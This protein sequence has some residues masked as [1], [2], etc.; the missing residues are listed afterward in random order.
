MHL[1]KFSRLKTR[2]YPASLKPRLHLAR[3][4]DPALGGTFLGGR[5][6]MFYVHLSRQKRK[7]PAFIA[8][9]V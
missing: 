8:M 3:R 6:N 5:W 1:C 9:L 4:S 7:T 2:L